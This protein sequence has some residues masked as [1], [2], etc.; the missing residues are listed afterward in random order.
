ML[1]LAM[2]LDVS[3]GCLFDV[4]PRI[5]MVSVRRVRMVSCLLVMPGLVMLS[6]FRVVSGGVAVMF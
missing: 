6:R 3:L 4:V 2:L 1:F 5:N